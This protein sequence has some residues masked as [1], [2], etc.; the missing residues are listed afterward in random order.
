MMLPEP[1]V[2]TRPTGPVSWP[3]TSA[4]ERP[5]AGNR[6]AAAAWLLGRHP[7]LAAVVARVPGVVDV[8]PDGPDIDLTALADALLGLEADGAAWAAYEQDH[9]APD[10]HRDYDHWLEAGPPARPT[11]RA[12]G[13][14]SRGEVSRLR[15][16]AV[17]SGERVP[18]GV[19]D[20]V[21]VDDDG[22]RTLL[23][24]WCRA[25]LAV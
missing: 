19:W 13:P 1:A 8:A 22:R 21:G 14:M 5:P 20:T 6:Y 2:R 24:D 7:Q 9:P 10:D 17:L 25:L 11:T 16:L 4:Q 15:L 3:D 18:F 12:I 23:T